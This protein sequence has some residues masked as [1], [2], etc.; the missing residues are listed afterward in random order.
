MNSAPSPPTQFDFGEN[1]E[2]FSRNALDSEKVRQAKEDFQRLL[3]G[4]PLENRS[5]LD[6]GFGQGLSLLSAASGGARCLGI[7]IN[8]RCLQVLSQN[9]KA[10]FPDIPDEQIGRLQGSILDP[11]LIR[12]LQLDS[13]AKEGKF[14]I[15]H[16]W[17][18]LHHT[19][20]MF[21][22]IGNSAALVSE[23]GYLVLAIYQ[24]HWSSPVWKWVKFLYNKSPAIGRRLF[25]WLF[26]PLIY[27]AKWIVIR[28]NPENKNRGMDFYH[29]VI[30]WVGGYPYEYAQRAEITGYLKELGFDLIRFFPPVAPTGCMEFVFRKR[31]AIVGI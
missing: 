19:G 6:I 11:E 3:D 28:E 23:Q 26:Y 21:Q 29:D 7:D 15:V 16:S 1:W 18:V 10:F 22:A 2:D 17:G 31:P 13:R 30:D 4:I 12:K 25:I 14:D 24:T 27:L 5:F 20:S 8:A 9:R